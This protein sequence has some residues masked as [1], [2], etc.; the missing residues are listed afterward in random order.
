VTGPP[1]SAFARLRLLPRAAAGVLVIV[2]LAWAL[3]AS[4]FTVDV[5]EYALVT[6]FGSV[7]RAVREPGLHT[8][9]PFDKVVRL[10]ARLTFSRPSQ[11]EYLTIDKKNI[12]VESLVTWRVTDPQ[13]YFVACGTRSNGEVRLADI[14][15][16]EIGAV[17]GS[18]TSASLIAPDGDAQRFQKIVA[19][20]RERVAG[21]ARTAYGIEVID[22]ELL[23][24]GLPEQNR[25]SVFE[26]MKAERGKMAKEYRTAGE[27]QAKKIIA[28]ADHEKVRIEAEAYSQAQRIRGE[29][30]AEATRIYSA[31]FSKNPSF[32][33]FLRTLQAYEKFLDENTTVFLPADAEV[34]RVLGPLPRQGAASPSRRLDTAQK[35]K[36]P[37]RAGAGLGSDGVGPESTPPADRSSK[38]VRRPQ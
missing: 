10:D 17:L 22:V 9:A 11:A 25:A 24:L 19:D 12:V 21:F 7:V 1:S 32:Y 27:V 29:G 4:L 5:T 16:G 2:L 8:K 34:L 37:S 38:V 23:R 36:H 33:K 20:I 18:Y 28:Q 13:R 3:I 35:P 26:R 6:R 15:L 31:A 14:L 30:D